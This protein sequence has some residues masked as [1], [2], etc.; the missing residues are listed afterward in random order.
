M[1]GATP[2]F[3]HASSW[4]GTWLS[5]GQLHFYLCVHIA[6]HVTMRPTEQAVSIDDASDLYLGG[7][8]FG[9]QVV[10]NLAQGNF[11]FAFYLTFSKRFI[12]D[13]SS[14]RKMFQAE[15]TGQSVIAALS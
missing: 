11:T 14:C 5:T 9:H 2:P 7:P 1:L 12:S 4:R 15:M 13:F 6:P 8:R 3:P 10:L